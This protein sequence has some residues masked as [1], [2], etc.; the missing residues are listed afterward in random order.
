MTG[1]NEKIMLMLESLDIK[2]LSRN[3]TEDKHSTLNAVINHFNDLMNQDEIDG[4]A[5]AIRDQ[6]ID[7]WNEESDVKLAINLINYA[8]SLIVSKEIKIRLNTDKNNLTEIQDKLNLKMRQAIQ[9]QQN[10]GCLGTILSFAVVPA[11]LA[12]VGSFIYFI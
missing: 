6:S 4:L 5:L 8:H 10:Q 7:A 11:L 3:F 12:T 2:N 9:E 1:K